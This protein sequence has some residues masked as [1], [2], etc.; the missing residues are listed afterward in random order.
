M[1]MLRWMCGLT[2][3]DRVRNEIIR[4][5]VGVVPVEEKCGKIMSDEGLLLEIF[6]KFVNELKEKERKRQEDKARKEKEREKKKEKNRRDKGRGDKS[7]KERRIEKDGTGIDKA[8][9]YSFEEIKRSESDRDKKHRKRHMSSFDDDAENEKDHSRSSYRHGSDHKKLKQSCKILFLENAGRCFKEGSVLKWQVVLKNHLGLVFRQIRGNLDLSHSIDLRMKLYIGRRSSFTH[10][11]YLEE[12]EKYIKPDYEGDFGH[13]NEIG[14]SACFVE[15][16]DKAATLLENGKYQ[17]SENEGY[18]GCFEHV[19]EVGHSA[20]FD[21]NYDSST[22]LSKNEKY[23]VENRG[24]DGD[25][26]RVNEVEDSARFEESF[27]GSNNGDIEVTKCGREGSSNRDIEVTECGGED[28]ISCH[29]GPR[30]NKIPIVSMFF[31]VFLNVWKLKQNLISV[32]EIHLLMIQR[33]VSVLYEDRGESACQRGRNT[34]APSKNP[35]KEMLTVCLIYVVLCE[36]KEEAEIKQL[37]RNINFKATPMPAFYH[38]PDHRS[39]KNKVSSGSKANILNQYKSTE[40]QPIARKVVASRASCT[41]KVSHRLYQ[42]VNRKRKKKRSNNYGE[43]SISKKLPYLPFTMNL[44]AAQKK[45][46]M[47][48]AGRRQEQELQSEADGG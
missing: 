17:A 29:S 33:F 13:V 23:Q 6:D 35:G 2:R 19:N 8:D 47:D 15:N 5:K 21:E 14:H 1:R 38:E 36:G 27:G 43:I 41:E 40:E 30:L 39:E 9:T 44:A 26:E 4:E 12:V 32:L 34:S 48:R 10:N 42:S 25:S 11:R 22:H 3:D 16:H 46:R 31:R 37:W 28:S 20:R 45:P 7:R 24:Y 18:A